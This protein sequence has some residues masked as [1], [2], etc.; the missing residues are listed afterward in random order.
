M[1]DGP[2]VRS[3]HSSHSIIWNLKPFEK[4]NKWVLNKTETPLFFLW[5]QLAIA[6]VLFLISDL[7]RVFPDRL[8]FDLKTCKGL[9]PTVGLNV[10][11]LRFA[12][13]L[14]Y[15]MICSIHALSHTVSAITL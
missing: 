15:R 10:V 4:S 14:L 8:T 11:G 1:A 12:L 9:V 5:T 3:I 6:V 7:L 2:G 13:F